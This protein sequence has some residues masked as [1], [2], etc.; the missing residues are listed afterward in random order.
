[1][2]PRPE[3][4]PEEPFDPRPADPC[5]EALALSL[6]AAE[7]DVDPGDQARL[8][9][10]L[11]SCPSCAAGVEA[12]RADG[13]RIAAALREAARSVPRDLAPAVLEGIR[14]AA[15]SAPR[16]TAAASAARVFPLRRGALSR[17]PLLAAAA[18]ILLVVVTA[19]PVLSGRWWWTG[20]AKPP[21]GDGPVPGAQFA[22]LVDAT[23]SA[24]IRFVHHGPLSGVRWMADA[25]G[26]GVAAADFDGDGRPDLFFADAWSLGDPRPAGAGNRLYRNRGDGTFEDVTAR[27]G[28]DVP[29]PV[30]GVLAADLD[31]DGRRDLLLCGYGRLRLLANR[32]GMAFEDV[33]DAAGF[34]PEPQSWFTCAAAADFDGDGVLDLFVTRYA[35]Q[36]AY[37]DL[38]RR[39]GLPEDGKECSWRGLL[40]FC[41]PE[42]LEPET[43]RLYRGLGGLRFEDA[44]AGLAGQQPRYG[45]QCVATDADGDGRLDVYVA[46]DTQ[47]NS[48]WRNLGGMRFEDAALEAG[49]AFDAEGKAQAGMGV[50]AADHDGDGIPDLV[51]TNFSNDHLTLYR[52]AGR[53]GRPAFDDRS[54]AT[55]VGPLTYH[56]LGWGVVAADVDLDGHEDLLVANGHIYPNVTDAPGLGVTHAQRMRLFAGRP[57][58][59]FSDRTDGGGPGLARTRVHRGLAAADFDGDGR[60]DFVVTTVGGPPALLRNATPRTGNAWV[61]FRLAGGRGLRDAGGARVSVTA[62]GRSRTREVHLGDSFASTSDPVLHFGLGPAEKV[63]RVLVRWPSGKVTETGPL[64]VNRLHELVEP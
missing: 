43:D 19:G 41:G 49:C 40:V 52:G 16:T 50:A 54:T 4:L 20:G 38:R 32:G 56:D 58:G 31:G 22:R 2:T 44:S 13:E 17:I 48:L 25:V 28:V 27:A 62:G 29:E 1:V 15:A 47:A 53:P 26:S 5:E 7:G 55:G 11:G 34:G 8:G 63:D 33:S 51:V 18:A 3:D 42:P 10:H 21:G 57:D 39:A 23:E 9:A 60:I 61:A 36:E 24:G 12:L 45:F 14:R 6:L 37:R 30:C 59:T 64:P 35:D 46:N